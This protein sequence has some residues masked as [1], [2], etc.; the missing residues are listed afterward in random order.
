[1]PY[2]YVL[3]VATVVLAVRHVRSTYASS[4]SKRLVGG[5]AAFSILA[6]YL[7]PGFLPLVGWVVLACPFLQLAIGFYI[8]FHQAVWCPDAEHAKVAQAPH[9]TNPSGKSSVADP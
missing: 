6:P 3:L 1:M 2:G 4:R 5:L 8:I 7:W 9:Q